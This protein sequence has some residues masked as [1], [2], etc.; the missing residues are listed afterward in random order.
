MGAQKKDSALSLA[1]A[2]MRG[3]ISRISPGELIMFILE[4]APSLT[5]VGK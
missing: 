5:A 2:N 3:D 1:A 4:D